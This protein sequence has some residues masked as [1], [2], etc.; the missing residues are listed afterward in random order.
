MITAIAT[1]VFGHTPARTEVP[2]A[3]APVD[4]RESG[5]SAGADRDVPSRLMRLRAA[6]CSPT[7]ST[8]STSKAL[9]LGLSD[10]AISQVERPAD[11][12]HSG[13]L[14]SARRKGQAWASDFHP[15]ERWRV[16]LL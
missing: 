2:I 15:R 12:V 5:E 16:R 4:V 14:A 13:P 9:S 11:G 7:T 6:Q 3:I 10:V 1:P 8:S